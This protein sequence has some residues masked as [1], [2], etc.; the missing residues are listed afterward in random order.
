MISDPKISVEGSTN[1]LDGQ[2]GDENPK[3]D[4]TGGNQRYYHSY[5]TIS[6]ISS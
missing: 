2:I 1:I 5:S 4:I 3:N 6:K